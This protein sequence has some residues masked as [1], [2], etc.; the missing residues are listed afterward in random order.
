MTY[1]AGNGLIA[2]CCSQGFPALTAPTGTRALN[3]ARGLRSSSVPSGSTGISIILLPMGS[4]PAS[5]PPKEYVSHHVER[6]RAPCL[7][8][9]L[10]STAR[11]WLYGTVIFSRLLNF[12]IRHIDC[13]RNHIEGI[14]FSCIGAGAQPSPHVV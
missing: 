8:Q 3:P 6:S 1:R 14:C 2:T 4:S 5:S 10:R 9:P 12:F 11:R 13:K 7:S